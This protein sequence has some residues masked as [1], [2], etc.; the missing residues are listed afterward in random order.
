MQEDK[1]LDPATPVRAANTSFRFPPSQ[2]LQRSI[3]SG[4]LRV[5]GCRENAA[6]SGELRHCPARGAFRA[7]DERSRWRVDNVN[8]A[9]MGVI[10][11]V[12]MPV[13]VGLHLWP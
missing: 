7:Q 5:R 9:M 1:R 3:P 13:K 4:R 2:P 11:V 12:K 6:L 10:S 8:P